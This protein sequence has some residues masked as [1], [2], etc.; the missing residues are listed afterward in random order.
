MN[1]PQNSIRKLYGILYVLHS[2]YFYDLCHIILSFWLMSRP[3]ECI[4][5]CTY[6][7]TFMSMY[8]CM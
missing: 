4:N 8:A 5:I 2:L 3:V 6:V 7:R 1:D